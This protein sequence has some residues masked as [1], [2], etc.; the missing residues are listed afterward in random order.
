[1]QKY[2]IERS[3]KHRST[4]SLAFLLLLLLTLGHQAAG[5]QQLKPCSLVS[6]RCAN[7]AQVG[8]DGGWKRVGIG[9]VGD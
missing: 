9:R 4:S 1:M 2:A 7:K 3:L 5:A 6:H 8:R